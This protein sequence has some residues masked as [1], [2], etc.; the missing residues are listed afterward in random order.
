MLLALV[1]VGFTNR[2]EEYL[3]P[4]KSGPLSS[5]VTEGGVLSTVEVC[6]VGIIGCADS[7]FEAA[8]WLM[9]VPTRSE[10]VEMKVL[11]QMS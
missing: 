6:M 2:F 9:D 10:K 1:I 4:F 7:V 11:R 3:G 8:G 5:C